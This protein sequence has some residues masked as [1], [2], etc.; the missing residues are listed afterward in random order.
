VREVERAAGR[1]VEEREDKVDKA[2]KA[3]EQIDKE[4]DNK[5]ETDKEIE[6][7]KTD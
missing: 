2:D 3:D 4:V 7:N 1:E 5:L 6:V